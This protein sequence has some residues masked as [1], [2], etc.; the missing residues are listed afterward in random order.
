MP[1]RLR[2]LLIVASL[3]LLAVQSMRADEGWIIRQL[4]V[5]IDIQPDGSLKI[6][7]ALD[8]DFGKLSKHGI[9]REIRYR[10]DFDEKHYRE[11]PVALTRVTDDA[12]RAYKVAT[13]TEGALKRFKIGDPDRTISGLQNYRIEYRITQALNPFSDHDELYWNAIGEWP[14][15]IAAAT[16]VVTSPGGGINRVACFEGV[17]GSTEACR[18]T[19][20]ADTA[21][22]AATRTLSEGEQMTIVTALRKGVVPE[23]QP[24]LVLKPR[25]VLHFFDR[26]P[27]Y[28][29]LMSLGF[30]AAFGGIGALWWRVG[31]DRRY[32]AIQHLQ[33]DPSGKDERVPLFDGQPLAV[34]FEPPD[35][36]RPAQMGL[37]IDERADT[38]DV[39]A[40]IV[41]L[42][43]RGYITITEIPKHGWF[44]HKDWQLDR[45]KDTDDGLLEYEKIVLNGLF[46]PLERSRKLSD[47][48]NKFHTDLAKAKKALYADAVDRGW[49]PRNPNS[50]RVV[51]RL[52]GIVAV[53]L[54]GALTI[55]LGTNWGAGL[56]GL[57]VIAAGALLTFAA[58]ALPRRTA[59]GRAILQRGLGFVRYIKTAEVHQQAFAE[60][61]NIFT[62]YL[63]Y[64][65]AFKCV[66]QW[67]RA[68]KDIDLQRATGGW[69]V[70]TT[71]FN[72]GTFSS[73]LASFSSSVSTTISSTPGGS[74]GSGFSGGSSGG[75][76]GGGG[77]GSW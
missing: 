15:R 10:F 71:P 44:G 54:G 8:V 35:A 27:T 40:T 11:Y 47:L 14:V 19:F 63:P 56:L 66:D 6:V 52:L 59:K 23:P 17:V 51:A 33:P 3:L 62:A 21:T 48:K 55:F 60:R 43:V 32:I 12:G 29:A 28:L 16:V 30:A 39:T 38:L 36:I 34:Q 73:S 72:A 5:R 42:A 45:V 46:E 7:D 65:I 68:F 50:V 75:G 26:T 64:A 24:R 69:Y 53:L 77:G 22:F 2:S 41:D 49:F 18:A 61:A 31:R 74:G 4:Q 67:A 57:P 70:G 37:L 1:G 58:S 9:F 13:S 25:D 20:T 76:G